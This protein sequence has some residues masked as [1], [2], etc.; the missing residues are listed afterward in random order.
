MIPALALLRL[1]PIDRA[2][3]LEAI[4][5]LGVAA[6][7]IRLLPVRN[8]VRLLA[9]DRLGRGH[10]P[11]AEARVAWAVR[12]CSAR[13][14]WRTVC[15]QEGLAAHWM[16]RRRGVASTL[17]YG[18][19]RAASDGLAAHVWVSVAGRPVVGGDG[20]GYARLASFPPGAGG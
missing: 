18:A 14:P 6:A 8:V 4:L 3:V 11:A 1:R 15:F 20:G 7:A 5:L 17:H 9:A 16:L 12:A 19:A 2:A 10:D 13:V